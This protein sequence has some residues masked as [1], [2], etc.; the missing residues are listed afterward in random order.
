MEKII[1]I[2]VILGLLYYIYTQLQINETF[3]NVPVQSVGG[4]DDTNAINTLAQISKQLM[5]GG[6]TVPGNMTVQGGLN[7]GGAIRGNFAEDQENGLKFPYGVWMKTARTDGGQDPYKMLFGNDGKTIFRSQGG[8][9]FRNE[10]DHVGVTVDPGGTLTA[11]NVGFGGDNPTG[12]RWG[13][14]GGNGWACLRG[15]NGGDNSFC[16]HNTHGGGTRLLPGGDMTVKGRNILA[17]IDAINNKKIIIIHAQYGPDLSTTS[18][19]INHQA[20]KA[21]SNGS[22]AFDYKI[23]TQWNG[24][25]YD[26]HPYHGKG[27]FCAYKCGLNGDVTQIGRGAEAGGQVIRIAC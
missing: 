25:G 6:V 3:E 18:V 15:L 11:N 10:K 23:G 21:N 1:I 16:M 2:L 13:N 8:F 5:A 17:E 24:Q 20:H 27:F 19:A 12:F 22:Y 4:V 26:P 14:E 9:Q 7:G